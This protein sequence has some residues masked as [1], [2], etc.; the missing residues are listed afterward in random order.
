MAGEAPPVLTPQL[1]LAAYAA[2]IFPMSDGGGATEVYWVEPDERGVFPLDALRLP[3]RLARTVAAE[4]FDVRVDTDFFGVID[5]CAAARPDRDSTWINSEIRRL[6]GELFAMGACHTV[7]CWRD[8]ALVG[9]L[10]GVRIGGAFF[11]ESMFHTVTDAS[12]VALA[13]LW[14]RLLAGGFTLLDT[15]FITGH[16]ASLGA[17]EIPRAEYRRR[18]KRAVARQGDWSALPA[19]PSGRDVVEIVRGPGGAAA[20]SSSGASSAGAG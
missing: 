4:V 13:H 5:N 6:Y 15:Q 11:G 19:R 14:A 20:S 3:R 12:K 17:V 8:G 1:L 9:G 18:L 10:Y 16:L 7:E 2:G